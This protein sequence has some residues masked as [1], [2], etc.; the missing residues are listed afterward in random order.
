[1]DQFNCG[2]LEDGFGL[3]EEARKKLENRDNV[4]I[5]E[6]SG[7]QCVVSR[8]KD[9]DRIDEIIKSLS[10][11]NVKDTGNVSI[12]SV[13]ETDGPKSKKGKKE[14]KYTVKN[15]TIQNVVKLVIKN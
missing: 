12:P 15:M 3:I 6:E 8:D 1:M 7:M 11:H 14:K 13:T 10:T 2:D 5:N 4:K 9:D